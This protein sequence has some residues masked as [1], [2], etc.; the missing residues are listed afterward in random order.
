MRASTA[1]RG[2]GKDHQRER[3][4]VARVVDAGGGF[5]VNPTC[6]RWIA[7]GSKWHLGHDHRNG[8]YAGPEHAGCNVAERNKRHARVRRRKSRAW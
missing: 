3:E 8:G 5:C 7:P 6:G 4:R 1:D 2:Y